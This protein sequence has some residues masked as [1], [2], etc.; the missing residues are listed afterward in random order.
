MRPIRLE[1]E[2]FTSFRDRTVVDFEDTDLFVLTGPTG[3]GKSSVIDAMTFALYGSIPRLD[4]LGLVAPVISR[5]M[6]QASVR[7]DFAVGAHR[8]TAVR[9]VRATMGNATTREARLEDSG[10]NTLAGGPDDLTSE[11]VKILG[12]SFDQ[13]TKS[14][15]LPQGDFADLLH[16]K[17]GKRQKMLERLLGTEL[18][19]RLAM[20]ARERGTQADVAARLRQNDL[21]RLENEGITPEARDGALQRAQKLD[22]LGKRIEGQQPEIE[23]LE[24]KMRLVAQ[25]V[26]EIEAR[27]NVLSGVRI[28]NDVPELAG[29]IAE[30]R[31]T[32]DQV[33]EAHTKSMEERRHI[34]NDLD[35]Q[36]K[37]A[38]L[39]LDLQRYEDLEKA[40]R[41]GDEETSGL[42]KEQA[43]LKISQAKVEKA[44]RRVEDAE[45][46]KRLMEDE[47]RAYHLASGL[48]TGD[49][50]PVCHQD[51]VEP[52][53]L[54]VPGE[55]KE[56]ETQLGEAKENRKRAETKLVDAQS[57]V[58]AR[59][60]SFKHWE[61]QVKLLESELKDADSREDLEASLGQVLT[62]A[63]A[64]RKANAKE[65]KVRDQ[66][67]KAE[68]VVNTLEVDEK[69]AWQDYDNQRDLLAGMQPPAAER[70]DLAAA[71]QGLVA[72]SGEQAKEQG[73]FHGEAKENRKTAESQ[74]NQT[75]SSIAKWC[76]DGGV[77]VAD[78]E[79]PL[80]ACSRELGRQ[81]ERADQIKQGLR[82]IERKRGELKRLQEESRVAADLARHL[83]ARNFE[84]WLMA[85]V[86]D[87]LCVGASR[88]LR[89]LS[90]DS[91]SLDRDPGNNFIVV[92][93][94]NADERRPVKTLS[95]GETFLASLS[96]ALALSEDLADLAVGGAPRLEALFLDEGFG[97][98][99]TDTLGVVITAIEEL[100]SRGRMVGIVTHVKELAESIPVRYEVIKEG[101]RSSI[102][103]IEA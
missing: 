24:E 40:R 66:L 42:K 98:L 103:R 57:A 37:E 99:D 101:N 3:A 13:F 39:K 47:H 82:E 90:S 100:G 88:E 31:G 27:L 55:I 79:E 26:L 8:Y 92:D 76:R 34:Q 75:R 54:E 96:L 7:L 61:D 28:P 23:C 97:T 64:L 9:V 38:D 49:Q 12:L 10:G 32:L 43:N 2:G 93:H 68:G 36:P 30:G 15:V 41:K 11:V 91:Y 48:T 52:P 22:R 25:R 14:V 16:E 33:K 89:K 18:F 50:C 95:G 80:T 71:W 56:V 46:A 19:G 77:E 59:K 67:I 94:R 70:D 85:Q 83:D 20:R 74:L 87:Q 62:A 78:G 60:G 58:A 1:M 45:Q 4:H 17:A 72:W 29:K 86:L 63:G 102:E 53:V 73:A 6:L 44:R 51:V 81:T 21:E 35:G 65:K 5:G 84:R 69:R